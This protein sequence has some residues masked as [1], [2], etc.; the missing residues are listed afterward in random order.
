MKKLLRSLLVGLVVFSSFGNA[1]SALA[2]EK[3]VKIT[4]L[5]YVQYTR[6]SLTNPHTVRIGEIQARYGR[7]AVLERVYDTSGSNNIKK[8]LLDRAGK[9]FANSAQPS[10]ADIVG[11]M[12]AE[13][14]MFTAKKFKQVIRVWE[15]GKPKTSI[16]ISVPPVF[17]ADSPEVITPAWALDKDGVVVAQENSNHSTTSFSKATFKTKLLKK[18]KIDSLPSFEDAAGE[19]WSKT[20]NG[21]TIGNE[22]SEETDENGNTY[23]AGTFRITKGKTTTIAN[24]PVGD[25]VYD[26]DGNEDQNTLNPLLL[27]LGSAGYY[28]KTYSNGVFV[29]QQGVTT[30]D[31]IMNNQMPEDTSSLGNIKNLINT[32]WA[33]PEGNE[34][35]T[36]QVV[37]YRLRN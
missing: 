26:E 7:V 10:D 25:Y 34:F 1:G 23:L 19:T 16:V 33:K 12:T 17:D 22:V 27:E 18:V 20:E 9:L 8:T 28:F 35:A 15:T 3:T 5:P 11:L 36:Y 32:Q 31:N 14:A 37:G 2:Q 6:G 4:D 30:T 29:T 24:Y 21:E 13:K